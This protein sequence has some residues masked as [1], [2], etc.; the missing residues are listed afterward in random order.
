MPQQHRR[1]KPITQV[2][3]SVFRVLTSP[4]WLWQVG[5][6]PSNGGAGAVNIKN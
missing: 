1:I 2:S 3:V 5:I 6:V 4:E